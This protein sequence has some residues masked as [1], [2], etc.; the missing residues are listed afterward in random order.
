MNKSVTSRIAI[1]W[2][3]CAATKLGIFTLSLLLLSGCTG[4]RLVE[5]M[6]ALNEDVYLATYCS[7][8][9][10]N[11]YLPHQLTLVQDQP[12]D[13]QVT[14]AHNEDGSVQPADIPVS[15]TLSFQSTQQLTIHLQAPKPD[16]QNPLT[17]EQEK[18]LTDKC[19]YIFHLHPY[20]HHRSWAR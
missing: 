13:L 18:F 2:F 1:S 16:P 11:P 20:D 14:I 6:L 4:P 10:N 9:P 15:A 8:L 12:I 17:P 19:N 5:H 7:A 3:D